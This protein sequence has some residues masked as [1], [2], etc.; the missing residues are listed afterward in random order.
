MEI[1]KA[2]NRDIC[3]RQQRLFGKKISLSFSLKIMRALREIPTLSHFVVST[4]Y[5]VFSILKSLRFHIQIL[6]NTHA[7]GLM[8]V[9]PR[10][11]KFCAASTGGLFYVMMILSPSSSEKNSIFTRFIYSELLM[12]VHQGAPVNGGGKKVERICVTKTYLLTVADTTA[13]KSCFLCKAHLP[14]HRRNERRK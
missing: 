3:K 6:F 5:E 10:R 11:E 2:N 7:I 8:K 14:C 12:H 9:S 13:I 4:V 1:K